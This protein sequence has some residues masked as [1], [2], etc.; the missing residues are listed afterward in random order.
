MVMLV[1][2]EALP[3][4][5][6]RNQVADGDGK[7]QISLIYCTDALFDDDTAFSYE[8][9]DVFFLFFRRVKDFPVIFRLK[10]PQVD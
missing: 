10:S 4:A 7:D 8:F 5:Y 2:V 6:F 3:V 9:V 1:N